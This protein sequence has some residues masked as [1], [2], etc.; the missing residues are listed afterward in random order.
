MKPRRAPSSRVDLRSLPAHRLVIQRQYDE[1]FAR[2]RPEDVLDQAARLA[3]YLD[4]VIAALALP[5]EG[6]FLDIGTGN[7]L[8]ALAI[9]RQRPTTRVLGIDGSS[10]GIELARAA[11]ASQRVQN[12]A[13]LVADAESPPDGAAFDRAAALSVLN[14]IPDKRAAL[15]SWRRLAGEGAR[16]VVTDGFAPADA[17][18]AASD[19]GP[20]T[21]AGFD[22]LCRATGWRSVHREDLTPLVR[23]LHAQ[24]AWLWPEYLQPRFRYVLIALE[25]R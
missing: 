14:L 11:A 13:F 1:A 25:P 22:A 21:D 19:P 17:T 15:A 8:A 20:L 12:A 16:V 3:P 6:R 7:G 9:A 24:K 2:Q 23:K 10:K 18:D 4:R 5:D